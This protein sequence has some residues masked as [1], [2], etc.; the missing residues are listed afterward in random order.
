MKK[1]R[2]YVL[3]VRAEKRIVKDALFLFPKSFKPAAA[4]GL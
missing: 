4:L 3:G 2:S 1:S